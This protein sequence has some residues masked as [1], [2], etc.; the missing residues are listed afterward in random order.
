MTRLRAGRQR[1]DR[2][3]RSIYLPVQAVPGS[4]LGAEV[5]LI[6]QFNPVPKLRIRV[7]ARRLFHTSAWCSVCLTSR[8]NFTFI[9]DLFVVSPSCCMEKN[10]NRNKKVPC[11]DIFAFFHVCIVFVYL[12]LM[13]LLQLPLHTISIV[14]EVFIV[15]KIHVSTKRHFF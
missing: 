5:S 4:F 11:Y 9:P 1:Q 12:T 14:L 15:T 13:S 3:W 7:V 2:L 8:D 6:T 10:I